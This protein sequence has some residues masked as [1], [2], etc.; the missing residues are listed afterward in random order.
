MTNFDEKLKQLEEESIAEFSLVAGTIDEAGALLELVKS[1]GIKWF[2]GE[3]I[4]YMSECIYKKMQTYP[5]KRFVL[6]FRNG[7]DLKK[8]RT[9]FCTWEH[10]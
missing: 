3:P 2:S 7:F 10:R 8:Q 6:N 4:D 5:E 1:N 9:I